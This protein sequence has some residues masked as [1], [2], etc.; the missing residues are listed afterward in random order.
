MMDEVSRG[1]LF[2]MVYEDNFVIFSKT[3]EEQI[4]HCEDVFS[5]IQAA[6]LKLK[7]TQCS[8]AQSELKPLGH[9]LNS[10][11]MKLDPDH[12]KYVMGASL[13]ENVT[14]LSSFR[15]LVALYRQFIRGV[16]KGW[17]SCSEVCTV[18]RCSL[19]VT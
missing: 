14:E 19:F 16:A 12:I 13:P 8:F 3:L 6:E 9:I 11:G 2:T 18:V 4:A 5:R 7:L 17:I 10:S 1:L 15:G